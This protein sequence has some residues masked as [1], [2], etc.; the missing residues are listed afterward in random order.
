MFCK[1]Y[2]NYVKDGSKN[3]FIPA[4]IVVKQEGDGIKDC[5][6][7]PDPH[8]ARPNKKGAISKVVGQPL[9]YYFKF[10]IKVLSKQG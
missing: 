8:G 4:L 2:C 7:Q 3:P 10:N 1:T 5:S 6:A 9:F